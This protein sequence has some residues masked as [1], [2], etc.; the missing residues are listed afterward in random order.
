MVHLLGEKAARC[1]RASRGPAY[2][3]L[4]DWRMSLPVDLATSPPAALAP[5]TVCAVDAAPW[6]LVEARVRGGCRALDAG[7]SG[8]A[9][10]HQPRVVGCGLVHLLDRAVNCAC[11]VYLLVKKGLIY[12]G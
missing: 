5:L 7:G 10:R 3:D 8:H 6:M 9:G 1:D 12:E 4:A 2:E 11:H